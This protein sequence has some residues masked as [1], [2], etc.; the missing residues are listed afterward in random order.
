MPN[1]SVSNTETKVLVVR[2]S[3]TKQNAGKL[4]DKKPSRLAGYCYCVY[5]FL[6]Q[7]V[8]LFTSYYILC[9]CIYLDQ[10]RKLWGFGQANPFEISFTILLDLYL[11][12]SIF[13][14]WL[15]VLSL[16]SGYCK[17]LE[18]SASMNNIENIFCFFMFFFIFLNMN[19][20]WSR[21]DWRFSNFEGL[22]FSSLVCNCV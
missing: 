9:Q 17:L 5:F 1:K 21:A 15:H 8:H 18:F 16:L 19:S 3:C 4:V 22:P 12:R 7:C 10:R 20:G 11:S 14:N 6:W 13:R 2:S